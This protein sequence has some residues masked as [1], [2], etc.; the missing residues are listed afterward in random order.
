M[1]SI[2]NLWACICIFEFNPFGSFAQGDSLS[3][4]SYFK[5]K[6]ENDF[7]SLGNWTDRYFTNGIKLEYQTPQHWHGL[8]GM[9]K[10]YPVLPGK[11]HQKIK[12]NLSFNMSMYTPA[13][14]SKSE[15]I[16]GDRPYAG[17]AY[18]GLSGISNDFESG[19]RIT[20]E[21][22]LGM[23]GPITQQGAL[24][25]AYHRFV[26][27]HGSRTAVLPKGWHH[28]LANSLAINVKTEY[29]KILFSPVQN[30]E[31]IGG[32]EVNFG[33]IT[34]SI[35]LNTNLRIGVFNDYFYNSSGLKMKEKSIRS[36]RLPAS[37]S[38]YPKNINRKFQLYFYVKP[39]FRFALNNSLL[40][41]S[42][43]RFGQNPYVL[44]GDQINRFYMNAD[45]GYGLVMNRIGLLFLQSFRSPEFVNAKP[46]TWG[47]LYLFFGLNSMNKKY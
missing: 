44:K 7:F 19:S 15:I 34:N 6:L 14:L 40:E 17:L 13:D 39:S 5:I 41:G 36:E 27:N 26:I 30:I 43:I 22:D 16:Q 45:F 11:T 21:Y 33:T 4:H 12:L 20:T 29:E 1:K 38:F 28:Q 32:F 10:L 18:L 24:Q 8:D 46:T 42:F 23:I 3:D 31:A 25:T 37:R 47:T 9:R 35:G 2:L